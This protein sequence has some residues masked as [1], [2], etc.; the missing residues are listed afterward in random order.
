[1]ISRFNKL[2]STI[3]DTLEF[4]TSTMSGCMDVIVV[5]NPVVSKSN[6]EE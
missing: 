5:R 3:S 2:V 4:N 1:M 6:N